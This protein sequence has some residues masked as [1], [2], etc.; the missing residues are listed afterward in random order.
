[1]CYLQKEA[2]LNYVFY[3]FVSVPRDSIISGHHSE[4]INANNYITLYI[5]A[6]S[7]SRDE[8]MLLYVEVTGLLPPMGFQF[9]MV[10]LTVIGTDDSTDNLP[11]GGSGTTAVGYA[12]ADGMSA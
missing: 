5:D 2:S 1:M 6:S 7:A 12:D 3:A 10:K 4:R 8:E 11:R 9:S